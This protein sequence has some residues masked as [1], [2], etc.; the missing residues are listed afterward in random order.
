M[1]AKNLLLLLTAVLT[2]L[3]AG[4]FYAWSISVMPGLARVSD[5]EFVAAMRAMNR[6]ILNPVFFAA[7]LGAPVALIAA[8]IFTY[9]ERTR[10][11]LLLAATV[12][13]LAG[14]FAVTA[15]GNVPLNN[16]LDAFDPAA[17]ADA[18]V[19]AARASFERRWTNLN[20]VRAV[21]STL[22]FA[23]VVAACLRTDD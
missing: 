8:T 6:A 11:S 15:F 12:I 21:A 23:L 3:M 20:H 5:R 16:R 9:G 17:A 2:G 1:N 14:N 10:F 19:A 18:P 22:A 4:L 7:F 13:Y